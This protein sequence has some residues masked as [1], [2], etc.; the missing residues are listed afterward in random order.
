MRDLLRFALFAVLLVVPLAGADAGQLTLRV[1]DVDALPGERVQLEIRTYSP[2]PV[3]QGQICLSS[4]RAARRAESAPGVAS[5]A[6]VDHSPF[7][8]LLGG[9]VF[10]D[11]DDAV[12]DIRTVERGGQTLLVVDFQSPSGTIN[13][14]D[15]PMVIL[16]LELRSDLA[17]GDEFEVFVDLADTIV[18]DPAAARLDVRTEPGRLRIR[19][20]DDSPGAVGFTQSTFTTSEASRGAVVT[21]QR[22]GGSSG[23]ASVSYTTLDG[24][25]DAADYVGASGTLTWSDDDSA[26][27]SFTVEVLRDPPRRADRDRTVGL[28]RTHGRGPAG[29]L[30]RHP[31]DRRRRPRDGGRAGVLPV[32]DRLGP[33]VRPDSAVDPRSARRRR[34]GA[35][36]P[37]GHDRRLGGS[38]C[39]LRGALHGRSPGR[40]ETA[41]RGWLRCGCSA[42]RSE[43]ATSRSR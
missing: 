1:D 37:S 18:L 21:V 31:R 17:L 34:L 4:R 39:G 23:P 6:S 38:G 3:G 5:A 8:A 40:Q 14:T 22:L 30:G 27:K 16:D 12:F 28:G 15:G 36:R 7:A 24:S 9:R 13:A 26:V 2:R 42:M 32:D 29:S 35:H 10:S 11:A 20:D 33:R 19:P 25:A 41:H 43:R